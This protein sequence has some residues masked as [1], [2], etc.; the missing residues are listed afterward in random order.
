MYNVGYH[1][2]HSKTCMVPQVGIGRPDPLCNNHKAVDHLSLAHQIRISEI[3]SWDRKPY[4][5]QAIFPRLSR[6]GY[7]HWLYLNSRTRSSKTSLLCLSD[8]IMCNCILAYSG[9]S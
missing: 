7:I 1:K 5:T 6:E 4:L 8:V 3:F 9:T 2:C